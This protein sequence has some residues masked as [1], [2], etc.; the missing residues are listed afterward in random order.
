MKRS[1][2][3]LVAAAVVITAVM[4]GVYIISRDTSTLKFPDALERPDVNNTII[5]E[6]VPLDINLPKP[7]FISWPR[8]K[9][10]PN[11]EKP[12]G[13]PR[14]PFMVP[15]GTKNVAMGKPVFSSDDEPIFGR[16]E[17]VTDGRKEGVEGN[18]V[19]LSPGLQRVTID[20]GDSYNI[21]AVLLW[22]NTRHIWVYYDVIVQISDDPDFITNVRT[23]FNNDID[24]SAG[25]GVG[26]DKHYIEI[27]E[28]KLIDTGGVRGRYI[29]FYSNGSSCNELNHYV[30]VE[31]YGKPAKSG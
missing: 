6:L 7:M 3:T 31:V 13:K 22:H 26:V 29:R 2:I 11:L 28:G 19:E 27:H 14:L 16:I 5:S 17:M 12:F 10:V 24:N 1:H 25:F 4:F 21:Y 30:E 20:L 23:L 8:Y 9:D 18:Y 15:A